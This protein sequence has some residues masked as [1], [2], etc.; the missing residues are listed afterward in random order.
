MNNVNKIRPFFQNQKILF[1]LCTISLALPNFFLFF[2]EHMPMIASICNV[3]L[4]FAVF[5]LIMTASKTPGKAYLWMFLFVFFGAF[6][7]VLLYLFGNSVIAVDM[8]LNLVTTNP[9]EAGE[10]LSN[11]MPSVLFVIIV[12]VPLLIWSIYAIKQK[13]LPHS[14]RKKQRKLALA[15]TT[16]G[17]ILL[18]SCYISNKDYKIQ[19]DLY[20]INVMYN[21][22]QAISREYKKNKYFETSK[23]F[24]FNASATHDQSANEIY[25]LVI[26]ETARAENFGIYG[27]KRNTTPLLG[28]LDDLIVFKDALS[29]SNT[30][31]KSVPM[32]LS[33]VSATDFD[34]IYHQKGIITA[35][36]E[37]GFSTTFFS[38]QRPNHSFIDYFGKEAT[39]HVFTKE[40]LDTDANV[41]DD[42]LLKLTREYLEKDNGNK[43]FIV[44]HTYGSH[45]NYAERYPADKAHYKPDIVSSAKPEFRDILVNAYDNTIRYTDDFLFRLIQ[46]V[47]SQD[48][49][50]CVMY[51]SDH[52]EDIFDDDRN[53]FLH[54]SPIPSIHQVKVPFI[55][56]LSDQYKASN[57]DIYDALRANTDKPVSSNLAVFH[58]MLDIAG[59]STSYLNPSLSLASATYAQPS[60]RLYLTDHN[61]PIPID[62]ILKYGY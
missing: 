6:Q 45:F 8:F 1:W 49:T 9:T 35:F 26:G 15:G 7:L 19:N 41:S 21:V 12:Y 29:Q 58:T 18:A 13:P 43:K 47:K 52:G 5:W 24:T 28:S 11:I 59:I 42:I 62:E 46:T 4:P 55:L 44:L 48:A 50:A 40:D 31:H 56:W 33:A 38:N 14:F 30:T 25:V 10:L 20:P 51:V 37:V 17:L 36:N 16:I 22:E 23:D 32:L 3:V 54:A 34:S 60:P 57:P 2:T 61:T 27:Y 39:N 53:L